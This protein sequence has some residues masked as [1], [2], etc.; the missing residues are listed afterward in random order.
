MH[1]TNRQMQHWFS[2][3]LELADIDQRSK[4]PNERELVC[5]VS[6]TYLFSNQCSSWRPPDVLLI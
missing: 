5:T 1:H 6:V 4:Q 2:K 3:L